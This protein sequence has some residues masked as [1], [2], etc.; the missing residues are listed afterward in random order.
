MTLQDKR[1]E[2]TE[3]AMERIEDAYN[4]D[5]SS[6]EDIH[7][8]HHELFNSDYY[9]IGRYQAKQWLGEDTFDCIATVRD[10]EHDNFGELLTDI[11]EPEHVVNMYTYIIGEEILGEAVERF[12]ENKV[13][14]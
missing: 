5:P 1:T 8:L 13:S 10:Y 11:S 3:Y 2:I 14:S 6:I 4:Y 7:D 12:L 9:I